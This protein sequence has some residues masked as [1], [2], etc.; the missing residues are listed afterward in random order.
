MRKEAGSVYDKRNI[1][2]IKELL[3][4]TTSPLNIV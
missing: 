3:I 1:S 4:G 2:V